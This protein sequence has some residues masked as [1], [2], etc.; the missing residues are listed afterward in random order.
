M[1]VK[2]IVSGP[3]KVEI[4]YWIIV[5]MLMRPAPPPKYSNDCVSVIPPDERS[6]TATATTIRSPATTLLSKVTERAEQLVHPRLFSCTTLA[7]TNAPAV[8]IP[9]GACSKGNASTKKSKVVVKMI[10]LDD[11][12]RAVRPV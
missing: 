6:S 9:P 2:V 1:P 5:L 7:P 8:L 11:L 12:A 3:P 10:F 4:A